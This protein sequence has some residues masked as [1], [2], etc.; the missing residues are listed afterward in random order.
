MRTKSR[1][2]SEAKRFVRRESERLTRPC[3]ARRAQRMI[4]HSQIGQKRS[5]QEMMGR[6]VCTF[7]WSIETQ[8]ITRALGQPVPPKGGDFAKRRSSGNR[9]R[10]TGGLAAPVGGGTDARHGGDAGLKAACSTSALHRTWSQLL[11]VKKDR[12]CCEK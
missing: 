9:R 3:V 11:G 7:D 5:N 10:R 4:S 1:M 8:A 2:F 12:V 6:G